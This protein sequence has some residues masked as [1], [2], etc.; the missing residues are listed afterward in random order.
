MHKYSNPPIHIAN[1]YMAHHACHGK[2]S[3]WTNEMMNNVSE[4]H[5]WRAEVFA[6]RFMGN[7]IFYIGKDWDGRQICKH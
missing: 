4:F 2:K 6:L 3:P 1:L 7:R 5:F